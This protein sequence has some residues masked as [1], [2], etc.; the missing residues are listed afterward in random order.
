MR[1]AA[2]IKSNR[3]KWQR[4]EA[5]S[6]KTEIPAETIADNFVELTDDLSYAR[7]FY[8]R[9]QTVRYLNKLAG[10][11]FIGLYRYRQRAKGRFVRFWKEELPMIMYKSR[12]YMLYSF[13][14]LIAGVLLGAFSQSQDSTFANLI[15][16][17]EY[18]NM[19]EDNINKGDP[20]G[21]YKKMD[22][23]VMYYVISTNNIKVAFIAFIM[24]ILFSVGT[25][26]VMFTN[27]V[28]IGVFQYFFFKKGLLWTSASAIWLHGTLEISAIVIA[29]GAGILL[30]NSIMFPGSY[31]RTVS[32][33]RAVKNA[34]K[35][36]VG[37]VPVFVV[38]A[39]IESYITRMTEMP[40]A[41]KIAIIAVS[42]FF[43]I[44]Y[45][46]Y[47]PHKLNKK[48]NGTSGEN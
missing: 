39:F 2:F 20:M 25:V 9:S 14:A 45:F 30:G 12:K 35:I 3:E 15:L 13:I 40:D 47:Y 29:G 24:G 28:M 26:Y 8:P 48:I 41:I 32:V 46:F 33:Q 18:V 37:L 6:N 44:W 1:E 42:A 4:I 34:L 27:G 5:E 31:K 21:V 22:Q 17:S 36:V 10:Y 38:A 43:I 23:E 19:T 7:T 11:Y 16:G